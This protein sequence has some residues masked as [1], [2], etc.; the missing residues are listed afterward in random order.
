MTEAGGGRQA[1][2]DG[3]VDQAAARAREAHLEDVLPKGLVEDGVVCSLARGRFRR[4]P[5]GRS[6]RGRELLRRRAGH[7]GGRRTRAAL[8]KLRS[9]EHLF[10]PKA[11][12]KGKEEGSW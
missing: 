12:E 5:G 11:K 9:S 6:V 3:A 1:R 10:S 2:S 4:R 8:L 7:G